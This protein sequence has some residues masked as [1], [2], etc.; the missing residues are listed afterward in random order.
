MFISVSDLL[1]HFVWVIAGRRRVKIV[2]NGFRKF[3]NSRRIGL[4]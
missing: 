4:T 3:I 1:A 2:V